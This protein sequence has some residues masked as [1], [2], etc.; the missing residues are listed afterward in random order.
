MLAGDVAGISESSRRL[1]ETTSTEKWRVTANVK[2]V[3]G[4]YVQLG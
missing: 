2:Y 1:A 3:H 4:S